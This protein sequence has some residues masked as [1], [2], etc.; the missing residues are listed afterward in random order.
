MVSDLEAAAARELLA[1]LPSPLHELDVLEITLE[2]ASSLFASSDSHQVPAARSVTVLHLTEAMCKEQPPAFLSA[3]PE[4]VGSKQFVAIVLSRVLTFLSDTQAKIVAK[5]VLQWLQPDGVVVCRESCFREPFPVPS[6]SSRTPAYRHPSFY[7]GCFGTAYVE[8]EERG[9]SYLDFA[10]CKSLDVYRQRQDSETPSP[11]THGELCFVY[12]KVVQPSDDETTNARRRS[13]SEQVDTFQ[14]FLD[15]QQYSTASIT[16]YE[17]IFGRG[18]VSTGGQ[19]TTV[20]FVAKLGL[21]RGQRV[22]DVGCGIG[23]GDFYMASAFGV[24]VL[25]IDLS[26]NMVFR[27]M[28][29]W[30]LNQEHGATLSSDVAFEICDA[31]SKNF[32][33]GSFDVVY[34]RDALL[35][36]EGKT[37]LFA[38]FLRWLK[39]GG[40]LLISDYCR[41]DD[42][43]P[44]SARF[45]AYVRQRGYSLLSTSEY[46]RVLEAT[47]FANVVAEDRTTQFVDILNE[48][49]MRARANRAEFER[50]TSEADYNAIVLGWEAKL[51]RCA[52]GDQRWGLFLA[53]KNG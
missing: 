10:H 18:Y 11:S 19:A 9:F 26:T 27:A 46:Q 28:E 16:R 21:Q 1:L 24:S 47:G 49:L 31:T 45:A 15:N 3:V 48:E 30:Q 29:R 6:T 32:A 36:I 52:E 35:H 37:E 44:E 51:A 40:K 39:P 17:K 4:S 20:E 33:D 12:R 13:A 23:G 43:K 5:K 8:G 41:R 25:G 53:T 2:S 22:L 38:Q 50:E 42:G 14:N 34:S 7:L